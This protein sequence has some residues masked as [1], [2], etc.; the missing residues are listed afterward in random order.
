M[1]EFPVNELSPTILLIVASLFTIILL[2][3]M[4]DRYFENKK[5]KE[6]LDKIDDDIEID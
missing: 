3:L 1:I 5:D 6:A 4:F 2:A